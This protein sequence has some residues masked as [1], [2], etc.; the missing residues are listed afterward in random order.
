MH[1]HMMPVIVVLVCMHDVPTYSYSYCSLQVYRLFKAQN[2]F[3]QVYEL[4]HVLLQHACMYV[5]VKI[6]ED[7]SIVNHVY[8]H[9]FDHHL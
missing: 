1:T 5:W 8:I 7:D 4:I 9:S 2:F 6:N 3:V